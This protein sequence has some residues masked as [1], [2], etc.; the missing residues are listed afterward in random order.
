[1]FRISR[2][3]WNDP[4]PSELG[5]IPNIKKMNNQEK[6]LIFLIRMRDRKAEAQNGRRFDKHYALCY[7]T[8]RRYRRNEVY[9]NAGR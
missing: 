5:V 8:T 7:L 6:I 2:N 9:P 1:M 3:Q 4:L